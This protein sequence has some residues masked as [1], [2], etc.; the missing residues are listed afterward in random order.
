MARTGNRSNPY[1]Y[2]D[3]KL[4]HKKTWRD[5][6]TAVRRDWIPRDSDR[7]V[8][9]WWGLFLMGQDWPTETIQEFAAYQEWRYF[10]LEVLWELHRQ[11]EKTLPPII[12]IEWELMNRGWEGRLAA[13]RLRMRRKKF[14]LQPKKSLTD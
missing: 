3:W 10:T 12:H 9:Y 8:A 2:A 14:R 7:R 6:D 1:R 4:R 5:V 13:D 11:W